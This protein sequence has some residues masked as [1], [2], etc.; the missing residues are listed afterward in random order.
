MKSGLFDCHAREDKNEIYSITLQYWCLKQYLL[1]GTAAT[2]SWCR[3]FVKSFAI[4]QITAIN[5]LVE[6]HSV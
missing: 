2:V 3:V 4:S 1:Q 5:L 6:I